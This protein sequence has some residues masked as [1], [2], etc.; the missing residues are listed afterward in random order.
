MMGGGGGV[1][2]SHQSRAACL[3]VC[4]VPFCELLHG[5]LPRGGRKAAGLS[6]CLQDKP[7]MGPPW[8]VEPHF[9]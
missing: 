3:R 6:L 2:P 1:R 9:E 4:P 7:S 5:S 8:S